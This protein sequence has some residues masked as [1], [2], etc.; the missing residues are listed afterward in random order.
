MASSTSFNLVSIPVVRKERVPRTTWDAGRARGSTSS[1]L[2]KG[3]VAFKQSVYSEY[4]NLTPQDYYLLYIRTPDVRACVD[5]ISRR[6]ATWDWDV[7]PSIDPRDSRFQRAQET[8]EKCREFFL[9]MNDSGETWQEI[10]TRVVTDLL[11][12]DAGVIE[13]VRS[14]SG[15][16]EELSPYLG[17][18][19]YPLEDAHG[20][21]YG[22][23]QSAETTVYANV[24]IDYYKEENEDGEP[25]VPFSKED[26][27]YFRLFPN[28]RT[29][30][31][32]PLLETLIDECI[33]VVLAHEHA[34][35]ALDADEIPPG[36]LVLGGLAGPAADRARADLSQMKGKDHKI[37]VLT[38]SQPNAIEAKWVELRKT[39]KD[40]QM[41][42]VVDDIRRTIWRVFGVQP[43]ELGVT[44]NVP[45]A[46]AVTQMDV[47]SSHL[48]TPILELLSSKINAS[49]ISAVAGE[50][51]SLVKFQWDRGDK[52]KPDQ[53][54]AKSRMFGEYLK[55]GVMTVNEVRR[56]LGMLPV[57][58]GDTSIVETNMGPMPLASLAAGVVPLILNSDDT[59]GG[60]LPEEDGG[61]EPKG[62]EVQDLVAAVGLPE[63]SPHMCMAASSNLEA[64]GK[65]VSTLS[66]LRKLDFMLP[67]EW[68]D[69]SYF[70]GMRTIDIPM[71]A[72]SVIGYG[73]SIHGFYQ[74]SA[75]DVL[76]YVNSR[77]TIEDI[78]IRADLIAGVQKRLDDLY[79]KWSVSTYRYYNEAARTGYSSARKYVAADYDWRKGASEYH[80]L[81]MNYLIDGAGLI[82]TLKGRCMKIIEDGIQ[83]GLER[84][85]T[86]KEVRA[87]LKDVLGKIQKVFTSQAY[88]IMNWAGKLVE[89]AN[90]AFDSSMGSS[91]ERW[92][93]LWHAV[94]DKRT[95]SVCL[96]EGAQ[97]IRLR[98]SLPVLP[99]GGTP[100]GA[101]CRCVL[102]YFTEAEY[103][104]MAP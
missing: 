5:S 18:E 30:L 16:A 61:S 73:Q 66:D 41:L 43:V 29:I 9:R 2:Y 34:M 1:A 74:E 65:E 24:G 46:S 64:F 103:K 15:E 49:I 101:R 87:K 90:R 12:Y 53:L 57:D 72:N 33:T 37:R 75:K 10:L 81:S 102:E 21:L 104:S 58:G 51:A 95:C 82:G 32:T 25:V 85:A 44:E 42:E 55:R 100:C 88:R 60:G 78:N 92:H 8:A 70:K 3:G 54:L 62:V 31:G 84:S 45:K 77:S 89:L 7:I 47:S 67:S 20:K 83:P 14:E 28:N 99:G 76:A 97:P 22:Y 96:R 63:S 52:L 23:E 94:G 35:M 79:E 19:F 56:D 6:I 69:S 68:Q 38:S 36:L 71:L 26:I 11:V 48:I 50:D 93:V 80:T 91:P 4:R 59:G 27:V 98:S 40:L 86:P 13:I 17:S 39:P